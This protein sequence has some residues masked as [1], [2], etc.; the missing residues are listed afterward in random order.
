[1]PSKHAIGIKG[2]NG[3][4]L[5]IHVGIDTV[6]LK[7]QHFTAHIAKGA[8]VKT[9]DLLLEF[10]MAAILA[11]GYDVTTPVLVTNPRSYTSIERVAGDSV[12]EAQPL[13]AA[14]GEPVK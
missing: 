11:A 7:G 2:D 9:G 10:D 5:L 8:H 13:Y 12:Q 4:E 3:V 14:L 6:E 1:M